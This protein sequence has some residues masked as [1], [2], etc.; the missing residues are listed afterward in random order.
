MKRFEAWLSSL[1]VWH[2]VVSAVVVA[3]VFELV[4][5]LF[6][7]GIGLQ[8]TR[9]TTYI[10]YLTWGIRIHHGYVGILILLI[11]LCRPE[12]VEWRNL[13]VIIGGALVLSDLAHH[14]LVL[15]PL[16]GSPEFDWLYPGPPDSDSD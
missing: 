2:V 9:D 4:T 16:T 5:L 3:V 13:T 12:P 8:S 1:D 7:F 10:G 11:A 6:R 15:W 14:F